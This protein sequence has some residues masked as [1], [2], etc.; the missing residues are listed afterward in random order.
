MAPMQV[1]KISRP[2]AG[3]PT[4][5]VTK[6]KHLASY[7]WIEASAPTIAVPGSPSLWTPPTATQKQVKRDSGLVYIAQN[8]ARHPECPLE[9]LFRAL[10][11]THPSFNIR[12]VD[13]VTDRNNIRKLL[14]FINPTTAKNGL[15]PFS[16]EVEVINNTAIFCRSE[17]KTVEVIGPH[18]FRGHGH[19]FEKAYTTEQIEGSTG[20]H[21][22][23]SYQFGGMKLV[24]RY[25]TDGYIARPS[26]P[27]TAST[28]NFQVDDNLYGLLGSLSLSSRKPACAASDKSALM[29][30]T[31]GQA[32]PIDTTLEIKTRT[33]RKLIPIQE[34]L[35]QL[36]ASQTPNL[37]RAYHTNGLFVRPEV[38][39]VTGEL[40]AWE[41]DH[42]ADLGNLA[43]LIKNIVSVV[44]EIG[45]KAVVKYE[46]QS[47][48][49]VV[50]KNEGKSLLPDDLYAK[51][52][53]K[54][55]T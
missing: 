43:A 21:R 7:N 39:D 54:K 37:I 53:T 12:G 22:V 52:K 28:K 34:V 18:Q 1:A 6:V 9:P 16:I 26:K 23:I 17:T 10:Y 45:G 49:L 8:A 44:K 46:R 19:E 51:F 42:R 40:K 33:S 48:K 36:W 4:A 29:I 27:L 11:K 20:H 2:D 25:E 35:P 24:V 32:V 31:E 50:Y 13:L 47:N 30:M 15:E 5:T 38:E 55:A 41:E 3:D 14:S